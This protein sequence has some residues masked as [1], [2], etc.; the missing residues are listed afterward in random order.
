MDAAGHFLKVDLAVAHIFGYETADEML[1]SPHTNLTGLM[2]ASAR[3]KFL[4][5]LKE[6]GRVDGFETRTHDKKGRPLW[7][8]WNAWAVVDE[9][10]HLLNYEG[11]LTD[12]TA[13][14][15]LEFATPAG[16]EMYRTLVEHLP[17]VVFLDA[18]D[19]FEKTLYISPQV[20]AL[21]GYTPEEWKARPHIWKELLHPNDKQRVLAEYKRTRQTGE[22][23]QAE[24]RLRKKDGT[25]IWVGEKLSVVRDGNGVPVFL[26][27]FLLDISAQKEAEE[28]VRQSE[29][30]FTKVFYANPIACCITTLE[31]GIFVDANQAYWDLSGFRPEEMLGRRTIELGFLTQEQREDF[32]AEIREKKSLSGVEGRFLTKEGKTLQTLEFYEI[33]QLGGKDHLL[34]MFY[35]LTGRITALRALQESEERY[36]SL[37]EASPEP[38]LVHSEG[39]IVFANLATMQ[40][41]GATSAD[42]V[43]GQ[44]FFDFVYPD[45]QEAANRRAQHALETGKPLPLAEQRFVRLDG[46]VIDAEMV[47]LPIQ[48]NGKPAL[49]ILVRDITERKRAEVALRQSE[50]SYRGLFDS[51]QEAIY[52][53]DEEGRFLDVNEGAVK[54]YGYPHEFFL[55]KTPQ[56]VSAPGLNDLGAIRKALQKA[57]QGE[58]QQFEFWGQ[59]ANGEVFP[60]DVRLYK[61]TYFGQEV[62]F[63]LAQDITERKQA[64]AALL[65]TTAMLQR[66][67]EELTILQQ[68]SMATSTASSIDALIERVI[69]I[70][71]DSLYPDTCGVALVSENREEIFIHPASHGAPHY[72]GVSKPTLI[73]VMGKVV[74]TGRAIRLGNVRQDKA[75]VEA[76]PGVQSE[77][78]VPIKKG[79]QVIGVINVESTDVDAFSET[80]ERLLNTIAGNLATAIEKLRLL[81]SEQ[82]RRQEAELLR[83]AI[84]ALTS[85]LDLQ[86][87]YDLILENLA[88][89]VVYD[90]AS[91]TLVEGDDLVLVAGRGLPEG[92]AWIGKRF[93]GSAKWEAIFASH[94]PLVMADAQADAR[95]EAWEGTEYIRGWMGAPLISQG[96]VIGLLNADSRTVNAFGSREALLA[97]TFA[98]S[99]AVAIENAR[100]FEAAQRHLRESE[101]LRMTAETITSSL[102]TQE[103]LHAVLDNLSAVVPYDSVSVFQLEGKQVRL[104]AAKGLPNLEAAISKMFP[105]KD[106]LL[107][108][109]WDKKQP[110]ILTDAQEDKRF[111]KW[112]GTDYVH[113][114]MGVPLLFRGQPIGCLTID[115]RRVGAY[116][117]HDATL[118]M[119]FAHQAAAALENARLYERSK[120]QVRQLTVLR[121][122]DTAISASFDLKVTLNILLVHAI[123]ELEVDAAVIWLYLPSLR[124]LSYHTSVGFDNKYAFPKTPLR[125]EQGLA[126][127]AISQRTLI[128][129]TDLSHRIGEVCQAVAEEKFQTYFGIPLINKGQIQG[130]LEIYAHASL[131][132]DADWLNYLHTLAGQAAIAID[133]AQLFRNL[134]RSNQELMLAYDTTLEGWGKALELRDKDT[135][136]HTRRVTAMTVEL[137]R[138]MGIEGEQLA[139]I[140]RGSLLHDI[141]KMGIPDNI[142]NKPGPLT[143]EEWEIMRQHPQYAYDLLFPIPYLRPALDIP[144]CHHERWDG[145]GYPRGLKG[146]EIP[147][148]ARI[149]AVVDIWDALLYDRP[150]REAWE[151]DKVIAHLHSRAGN[152]LDPEIVEIFLQ[153]LKEKKEGRFDS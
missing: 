100:Q 115:S 75:Y 34:S 132:P 57:F 109:I 43:L 35:D 21:L 15:E 117:Q 27:G 124:G 74:R 24:Y 41:V 107:Q 80:D 46:S 45:D 114:W 103:V 116:T 16:E 26:Q 69:D 123:E 137:A 68:V 98:H 153:L 20:E 97:Q 44:S 70:I 54:M 53:Q 131:S 92:Y 146:E 5:A 140:L 93:P 59:R 40:I 88:K 89:I 94:Q 86:T 23:F 37:V 9:N 42:Q 73:G 78:C 82:R 4:R 29:A 135:E 127:Q 150:Y 119:A 87:L 104:T 48:Y 133:N 126:G 90:S 12:V 55:G 142:L 145:S 79:E 47:A 151:T 32:L 118:A 121:D 6:H 8:C 1:D 50:A 19:E 65:T 62:V 63:A 60:K 152:E 14:K 30:L 22:S 129:V 111:N 108:E 51:V 141:G 2:E 147:L 76:T 77:L 28:T 36:R 72:I 112:C 149:F 7:T 85:T 130:V 95:F 148:A 113:G 38:I 144:Y 49:Q 91:I 58:P 66:Q 81:E 17:A 122:I 138:R 83:E 64:E 18:A 125:I 110:L 61:G 120:K 25:Y 105:T 33:I 134:Q 143:P 106:A 67:V 10:G 96:K 102:D 52:I 13:R 128:H 11:V 139:H 136:G 39:K 3:S 71:S 99:A 31:E 84:E 56:A 101:S